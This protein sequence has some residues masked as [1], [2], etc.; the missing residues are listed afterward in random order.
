LTF[1]P[2]LGAIRA[3][4]DRQVEWAKDEVRRQARYAT[5]MGILAG[6]AALAALGAIIIGLIALYFWLSTQGNPFIALAVIGGGLLLLALLLFALAFIQRRPRPAVRPQVQIAHP[7]ALLGTLRPASY[8]KIVAGVEPTLNL[9]TVTLRQGSRSALLG[10]LVLVA[11]VGL[12][13]GRRL[14]RPPKANNRM[15]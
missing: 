3:D 2:L 11:I 6:M 5:L 1:A 4:I 9:A 10:T 7:A 14:Q 12:I 15:A 13:A 8:D